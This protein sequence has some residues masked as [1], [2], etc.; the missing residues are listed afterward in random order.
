MYFLADA[1]MKTSESGCALCFSFLLGWDL[2]KEPEQG[3]CVLPSSP[4]HLQDLCHQNESSSHFFT[5]LAKRGIIQLCWQG[6]L[7]PADCGF[8]SSALWTSKSPVSQVCV[9]MMENGKGKLLLKHNKKAITGH[10]CGP[11][12]GWYLW[13]RNLLKKSWRVDLRQ[14]KTSL[15]PS[16]HCF[17]SSIL[18]TV[19]LKVVGAWGWAELSGFLLFSHHIFLLS[20]VCHGVQ[21]EENRK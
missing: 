6:F 1:A 18:E 5:H 16:P 9:N 19:L 17:G 21:Q 12:Q 7:F 15:L 3:L 4:R 14:S 13:S 10:C 8:H 20:V 2:R 11:D